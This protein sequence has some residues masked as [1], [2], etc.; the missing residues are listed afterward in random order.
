MFNPK[1]VW[2]V[3]RVATLA[4]A[5]A[6]ITSSCISADVNTNTTQVTPQG[7]VELDKVRAGMPESIF[8]AARITFAVDTKMEATKGGKTQYISRMYN[9]KNGQYMA[10]CH[11]DRCFLL[12]VLYNQPVDKE[13]ALATLPMLVQQEAPKENFVD[14]TVLKNPKTSMAAEFHYFGNK[15]LAI[16]T[17]S[18]KSA[19][20]VSSIS[21]YA[22]SPE[23]AYQ[24]AYGRVPPQLK[25]PAESKD[26]AVADSA[27]PAQT[28]QH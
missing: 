6:L 25:I 20:K 3:V 16:V 1:T 7:T 24:V 26:A 10:Q 2:Q 4:G 9:S 11:D 13:Y 27:T 12:Q 28:A 23:R 18:D 17:Y 21:V 15:A 22:M 19:T 8:R 14:Q 5:S